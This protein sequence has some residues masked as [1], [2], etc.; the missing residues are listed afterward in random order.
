MGQHKPDA[1]FSPVLIHYKE[2][3][4]R[5][6][7]YTAKE[8][9]AGGTHKVEGFLSPST[10]SAPILSSLFLS[11]LARGERIVRSTAAPTT[12]AHAVR[13]HSLYIISR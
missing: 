8:K 9:P 2:G 6:H 4:T 13:T 3:V 1:G 11:R 5:A 12:R 10:S 7:T